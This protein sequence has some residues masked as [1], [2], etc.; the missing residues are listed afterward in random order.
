MTFI[1]SYTVYI[2]A[3]MAYIMVY[4]HKTESVYHI[5]G[6]NVHVIISNLT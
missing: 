4:T 3:N 5:D 6:R 2:V 1:L